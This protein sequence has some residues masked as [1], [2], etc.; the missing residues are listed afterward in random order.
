VCNARHFGKDLPDDIT[1]QTIKALNDTH[2]NPQKATLSQ[3]VVATS[4][5]I[6]SK[7]QT[8]WF[9]QKVL[10]TRV[11]S[12]GSRRELDAAPIRQ[13]SSQ[14]KKKHPGDTWFIRSDDYNKHLDSWLAYFL[15]D[16]K[17]DTKEGR[18]LK[19]EFDA[20]VTSLNL[21]FDDTM[22]NPLIKWIHNTYCVQNSNPLAR[23]VAELQ[24][25]TQ[26]QGQVNKRQREFETRQQERFNKKQLEFNK[27]QEAATIALQAKLTAMQSQSNP[28]DSAG[29]THLSAL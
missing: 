20:K 9:K 22:E 3:V 25:T 13:K 29:S 8:T 27:R 16:I 17:S 2:S 4:N 11:A 21:V 24:K 5:V 14:V 1:A 15:N 23:A 12:G 18:S 7:L 10:P 26:A 6:V 19:A 28:C